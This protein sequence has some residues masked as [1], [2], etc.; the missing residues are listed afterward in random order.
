MMPANV[1]GLRQ[2]VWLA[3]P[4]SSTCPAL[5]LLGIFN[6]PLQAIAAGTPLLTLRMPAPMAA[7]SA[8]PDRRASRF[9]LVSP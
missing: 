5:V 3:R 2:A 9:P 7:G 1:A 6:D 8:G 4:R